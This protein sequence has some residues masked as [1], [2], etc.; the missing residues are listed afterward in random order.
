M[1]APTG[2]PRGRPKGSP[3]VAGRTRGVPDKG[4]RQL[5]SLDKDARQ[6]ASAV[7]AGNILSTFERLGGADDMLKWAADNRTVFY[8]QILSRLMPA[9]QKGDDEPSGSTFNTQVNV[10]NMDD[11]DAALRIAFALAKG[12]HGN[13]TLAPVAERVPEPDISPQEALNKWHPAPEPEPLLKPE[14]VEDLERERWAS[15]LPLSAEERADHALIRQTKETR[16]ENYPGTAAEQ[17]GT[18][19]RSAS[20]RK[21]TVNEIRRKQLL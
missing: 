2:K 1:T 3:K 18:V 6:R 7:L 9:H 8:T 16:L 13:P 14:P 12:M 17:G 4:P 19:Q 21:P 5:A 11:R 20:G 15:E 10:S